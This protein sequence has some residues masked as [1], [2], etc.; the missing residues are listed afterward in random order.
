MDLKSKVFSFDNLG[1]YFPFVWTAVKILL[2]GDSPIPNLI[3]LALGH[4]YIFLK[5]VYAVKIHK[6]YLATP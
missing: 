2:F 5:D 4:L 3:G 6:D 1:G